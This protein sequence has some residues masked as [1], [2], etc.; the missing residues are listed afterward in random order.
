MLNTFYH[1]FPH[2]QTTVQFHK[3]LLRNQRKRK[4]EVKK[5]KK[6]THYQQQVHEDQGMECISSSANPLSIIGTIRDLRI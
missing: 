4:V 2:Q 1:S 6:N 5:G 3:A